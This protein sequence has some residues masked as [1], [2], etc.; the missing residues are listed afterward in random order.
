MHSLHVLQGY[1]GVRTDLRGVCL[2]SLAAPHTTMRRAPPVKNK[3]L[4][5][6]GISMLIMCVSEGLLIAIEFVHMARQ[7]ILMGTVW[8]GTLC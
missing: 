2:R 4:V 6:G 3:G 8:T 5:I 1:K 7:R